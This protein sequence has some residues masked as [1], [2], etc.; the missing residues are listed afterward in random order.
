MKWPTLL[1]ICGIALL[2]DACQRHGV[3]E[4]NL[5]QPAESEHHEAK[6]GAP[7]TPASEAK[8]EK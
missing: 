5:L 6:Q 8:P 4:L 3:Q 2:F 7:K 1:L